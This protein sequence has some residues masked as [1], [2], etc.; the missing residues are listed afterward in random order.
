[1]CG[2]LNAFLYCSTTSHHI[3]E[4]TNLKKAYISLQG[5]VTNVHYPNEILQW[6]VKTP[7]YIIKS[8]K[9]FTKNEFFSYY[10]LV[11]VK[12]LKEKLA[13]GD[14]LKITG[15]LIPIVVS[16]RNSYESSYYRQKNITH[17]FY[18]DEHQ[19]L[20]TASG[21]NSFKKALYDLRDKIILRATSG[22]ATEKT[23][24][25]VASIFF[26]YKGVLTLK[27]KDI[28]QKSGT[29]H[30]F[31]VS[32][33]HVGI[34][35]S[36]LFLIIKVLRTPN[37]Y[38][39]FV[40][41]PVLFIYI[42]MTGSPPSAIRAFIMLSVWSIARSNL[43]PSTGTNN[44]AV[45]AL[46]ILILNPLD[47]FSLGF[48]YTFIITTSLV[49]SYEKSLIFFQTLNE[50]N[51]WKGNFSQSIPFAHKAA[52]LLFCSITASLASWGLNIFYNQQVIP[53][54]FTNFFTSLL[55]WLSFITACL[56]TLGL[57]I[58]YSIQNCLINSL[59]WFADTGAV[60]W[61]SYKVPIFWITLYYAG[62]FS[63]LS[64]SSKSQLWGSVTALLILGISLPEN[65]NTLRVFLNSSSNTPTIALQFEGKNYII[66]A[67]SK[68]AS[69]FFINKELNAIY[70]SDSKASHSW[71]LQ[72]FFE[73]T[74]PKLIQTSG[75][76]EAY[77]KRKFPEYEKII[78]AHKEPA[79][80]TDF[81]QK[82]NEYTYIFRDALPGKDKLELKITSEKYGPSK[83]SIKFREFTK[84]IVLT[85]QNFSQ[86]LHFNLPK[87]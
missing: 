48:L 45:S 54:A 71:A 69:K 15:R 73:L 78:N 3:S 33:L 87:I 53:L 38:L 5:T 61:Q 1:M 82:E 84:K 44:L 13:F 79:V 20:E 62:I 85:N 10:G 40:L 24:R 7:Q 56:S 12:N 32:G 17:I 47:L 27:E 58:F 31:A 81:I 51:S 70:F 65:Q 55:A 68:T 80:S 63:Y 18:L 57:P 86:Q 39:P 19:L 21:F 72:D 43:L 6:N 30:L 8:E 46:I 64:K 16:S 60:Y 29:G 22:L 25:I 74:E 77:L 42:I 76:H 4:L 35:A 75:R 11:L 66:N 50:K 14:K 37:K 49:L 36:F 67:T 83:V 52:M 28:F 34:A 23:Q 41:L 26:G 2:A 59:L 9:I